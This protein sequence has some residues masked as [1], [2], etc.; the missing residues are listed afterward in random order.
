MSPR[1][2]VV[3]PW[4]PLA[5]RLPPAELRKKTLVSCDSE[6]SHVGENILRYLSDLT[7][8]RDLSE[9]LDAKWLAYENET[10]DRPGSQV[11]IQGSHIAAQMVDLQ[12]P[13]GILIKRLRISP[14]ATASRCS[15]TTSKQYPHLSGVD[16][17][18]T[19]QN[20]LTNSLR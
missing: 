20:S 7:I 9:S 3:L 11:Q 5:N 14:R 10:M 17:S 13:G 4:T 12:W 2:P 1:S 8:D 19:S 15:H 16:G 18:M 6:I